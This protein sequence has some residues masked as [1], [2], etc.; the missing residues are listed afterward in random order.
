VWAGLAFACCLPCPAQTAAEYHRRADVAL[1]NFLV[2]FWSGPRQYLQQQYPT[3]GALTG[4]WTFAQGWDVLAD[5]VERTS[6][7]Q[8]YGLL[9]SFYAGQNA[10]G[11]L[12]GFYDDECWMTM[13]LT[14]AYD[15]TEDPKYLAQAQTIYADVMQ[16]W[17]TNCCGTPGG[18]VWWDKAHTQKATAANAGAALAGARLYERTTNASY[19]SFA[20][21]VYAFWNANMVNPGTGEVS[22]HITTNGTRV[23]WHFTY[24]EGLMAG[25]SLELYLAT[26]TASYLANAN[27]IAGYL[28][29]NEVTWTAY[30]PVL[31]DGANSGCSGDCHE[32]KGPAIRYL[33]RLYA[34]DTS[35]TQYYT[36]LKACADAVWNLAQETNDVIFSVN[37]A[38]PPQSTVDEAQDN[39]ACMA[40]NRFAEVAGPYP[41]T[42]QPANQYEAENASIHYITLEALYGGYTGWA[43]LA[44]WKS[45]GS[46]V[47][48]T[49]HCATPGVHQLVFRYAAGAGDA[50]RVLKTNG[51][52]LVS[53]QVFTNTGA[54]S[55]YSTAS[56]SCNLPAGVNTVSLLFDSSQ[57]SANWLNLDSLTVLGDAPEQIRLEAAAGSRGSV[58]LSWNARVGETYTVQSKAP[59]PGTEWTNLSAP[60]VAAGTNLSF[61]DT[62]GT[63][64]AR[65]YRIATP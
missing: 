16:A 19:L 54:W 59:L 64:Q 58:L 27:R 45:N 13:V 32:F 39:A 22:D 11:W 20:Q 61:T 31:Y 21:Q 7:L 29:N 50:T 38:G 46:W 47:D 18:G 3:N 52:A 24:N 33:S 41:G 1:Q 12:S 51:V 55:N 62:L 10:S 44:N 6:G 25:A 26:G 49:I 63:T 8:Y 28:V 5:G 2:H 17:D 15:L 37:W 65:Y 53:N 42:G 4:Y 14:R 40:L 23:W 34:Q 35:K 43:Y 56:V 36:V 57:H 30:G 60:L 9:D 48:F